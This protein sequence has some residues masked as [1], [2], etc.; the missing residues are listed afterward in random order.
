MSV[1]PISQK[2]GAS[3]STTAACDCSAHGSR[4]DDRPFVVIATRRMTTKMPTIDHVITPISNFMA[5]H[6][7]SSVRVVVVKAQKRAV[8]DV[9]RNGARPGV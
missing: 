1:P 7:S 4:D 6:H 2:S 5:A 8:S 3:R 9:G